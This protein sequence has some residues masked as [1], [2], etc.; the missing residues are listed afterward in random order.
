MFKSIR[1]STKNVH[2]KRLQKFFVRYRPGGLFG[3]KTFGISFDQA[4]HI[5]GEMVGE[6]TEKSEGNRGDDTRTFGTC[7]ESIHRTTF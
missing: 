7:F 1:I 3:K 4:H 2:I 5:V 6:A